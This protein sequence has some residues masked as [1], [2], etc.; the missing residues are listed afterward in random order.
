MNLRCSKPEGR[1]HGATRIDKEK[2]QIEP[3]EPDIVVTHPA[4]HY[5]SKTTA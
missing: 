1:Q 4:T 2:S 3:T 5:I